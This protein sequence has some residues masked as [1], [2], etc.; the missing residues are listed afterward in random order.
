M[1]DIE[2]GRGDGRVRRE[3]DWFT[4]KIG[5]VDSFVRR[6]EVGVGMGIGRKRKGV[7]LLGGHGSQRVWADIQAVSARR[8]ILAE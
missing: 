8:V 5:L 6:E 4:V 1:E 7:R 2:V 3:T